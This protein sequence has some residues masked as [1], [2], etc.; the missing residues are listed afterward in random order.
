MADA[1]LS[2]LAA[3]GAAV[4]NDGGDDDEAAIWLPKA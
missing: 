3:T 1:T 2:R 4:E